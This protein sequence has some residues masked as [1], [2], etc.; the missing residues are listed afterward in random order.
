MSENTGKVATEGGSKRRGRVYQRGTTWWL[1]FSH[2]GTRYR[3]PI[4]A[5]ENERQALDALEGARTEARQGRRLDI[6][7]S[8]W[9]MVAQRLLAYHE[10]KG[11]RPRTL[12]RIKQMVAHLDGYFAASQV[13]EVPEAV[14]GYVALRRRQGAAAASI[15]MEVALLKQAFKVCGLPRLDAPTIKVSNVRKGFI[16]AEDVERIALHLPEHL[17]PVVWTAFYTGW[18]KSEILGLE[19]RDVDLDAGVM[20][21]WA[22]TTKNGSGRIFPLR[23]CPPLARLLADQREA[24]K[25]FE[26][27][28]HKIVSHVFHH[29]A[30]RP[31]RDMDDAWRSACEAAGKPA[32][33]FHD[34]R[35]SA[36]LNMRRLG[37][38]E[39]DVMEACGWRTRSMF[40]RYTVADEQGLAERLSRAWNGL[41][42]DSRL[43]KR[44]NGTTSAQTAESEA[45]GAGD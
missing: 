2:R 42:Q 22:G 7:H 11:T 41:A 17:R 25:A 15:R 21:L 13:R 37:V 9:P 20:R 39:T 10:A 29:R 5:A 26:R 19:W 36:A 28:A 32:T 18:R 8:R 14:N 6:E 44:L 33:L 23:A 27:R 45:S 38:S 1:D 4:E 31:I 12:A 30:G 43:V 24:T 16:E 40:A 3:R 35:R 34:L